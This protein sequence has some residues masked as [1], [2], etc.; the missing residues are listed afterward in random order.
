MLGVSSPQ[1]EAS[2]EVAAI[3]EASKAET[4]WWAPPRHTRCPGDRQNPLPEAGYL[5]ADVL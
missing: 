4:A 3:E 2:A 5:S 1:L